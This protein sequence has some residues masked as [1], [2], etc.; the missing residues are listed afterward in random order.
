MRIIPE[1]GNIKRIIGLLAVFIYTL[2]CRWAGASLR[3]ELI[4]TVLLLTAAFIHLEFRNITLLRLLFWVFFLLNP[5]A[6]FFFGQIMQEC[7]FVS[8]PVNCVLLN[9]CIILILQLLVLLAGKSLRLS[10]TIGNI[11]PTSFTLLNTYVY[12]FRGNALT[13]S[14]L[15]SVRTAANV[16]TDYDFTPT[17]PMLYALALSAILVLG[18]WCMPPLSVTWTKRNIFMQVCAIGLCTVLLI[19]GSAQIP[20]RHWENRGAQYS[21]FLLNFVIQIKETFIPKP[22]D[23]SMEAIAEL[24]AD[25]ISLPSE[26]CHPDI[27][28]IMNESFS[29]FRIFKNGLSTNKPVMPFIDSMT[30]NTIR[31]NLYSSVFGGGTANS[32]YEFLSGNTM[33]FLPTGSIVYQQY[34]SENAYSLLSVLEAEGYDCI[35]MHPYYPSGW[36]R[37]TVYPSM[38][39]D[40]FYS[41]DDFPQEQMIRGYVSDREMFEQIIELHQNHDENTPL[42]LFGITMQNHGAYTYEG[43]DFSPAITLEGY[44]GAYPEATQ[45]LSSIHETDRA[46]AYLIEYYQTVIRDVVIAFFGDHLPNIEPIFYEELNGGPFITLDE[47]M[48]KYCVPF[49]I[50]TN[51]DIME[52]EYSCSSINYLSLHVLEAAG[53]ALPPYYQFLRRMEAVIPSIST[54]GF[55]SQENQKFLP[56]DEASGLEADAIN[57]YQ[58]LQYNNIFDQKNR[59]VLFFGN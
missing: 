38:G 42:F 9:I 11:L 57:A 21:G 32:E 33:A 28:V 3:A 1:R 5:V 58:I 24:E 56:L 14:D 7:S 40:A 50:W 10:L 15:L 4:L 30:D 26:S 48:Q 36:M 12:M 25:F 53:I 29:D 52:A 46:V 27:I 59:S 54:S 39:F 31:G 18:I 8:V 22:D 16:M 37:N 47:Q 35:A 23:Y 34:F 43:T 20:S 55:Y 41:L 49:F 44:S 45:Y 17:A 19:F 2:C 13:P 6:T 51:Y